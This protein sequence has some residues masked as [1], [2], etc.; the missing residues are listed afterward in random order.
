MKHEKILKLLRRIDS[1]LAKV[2]NVF[3][4]LCL[5][6]M[7]VTVLVGV[8]LRFVFK[9]PN[10]YGEE[11]SRYLLIAAVFVG[12]SLAQRERAHLG[13]DTLVGA[14]P[15]RAGAFVRLFT[16]VLSMGIYVFLAYESW[17]FTRITHAYGQKSPSMTFLPMSV[18]YSF[19][20]VGFTLSAITTGMMIFSEYLCREQLADSGAEAAEETRGG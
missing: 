7:V 11:I 3:S 8:A 17:N 19:M 2:E 1:T 13:I 10:P 15:V 9:T 20:F 4:M 12:I 14:L 5:T 18:I 16:D 6:G